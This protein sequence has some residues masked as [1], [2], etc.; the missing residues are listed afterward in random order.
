MSEPLDQYLDWLD[1][2]AVENEQEEPRPTCD[3]IPVP[4]L[5]DHY[6]ECWLCQ[7]RD[8]YDAEGNEIDYE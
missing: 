5:F 7:S 2:Q 3:C 1:M 4:G 6:P 8:R